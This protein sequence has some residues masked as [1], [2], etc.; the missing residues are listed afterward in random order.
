MFLDFIRTAI[1]GTILGIFTLIPQ[2]NISIG[3]VGQPKTFLPSQAQTDTERVVSELLFRKLFKYQDGKLVNDLVESWKASEDYSTY[4][5]KLKKGNRWHDGIEVSSN[6]IIYTLTNREGIK[7]QIEIEK[8]S[9]LEVKISLTTPNAILP[10]LLTF[11]L[12]PA[13]VPNQNPLRPVGSTSYRLARI[14]MERN[15][16]QGVVLQSFQPDKLYNKLTFNF[17]KNEN[18][19][20]TAYKLGEI[21]TFLSSSTFDW[22]GVEKQPITYLGRYFALIFNTEGE[23]LSP[24]ENRQILAKALN[25]DDLLNKNYYVNSLKAQGSISHSQYTKAEAITDTYD[26]NAALTTNQKAAL[27]E[28]KVLLPNNKDGAQI[29]SFLRDSWEKKLGLKLNFN[30]LDLDDLINTAKNGEF[31]VL[32]IGEEV[33]PDPDRYIFW[34]STQKNTYNLGQ[35]EDLRADKAL[36]EGRKAFDFETRLGHYN[37]F[38]DVIVTKVPAVFLY[39]PGTYLY[40]SNKKPIPIPSVIYSPS[41]IL[42][43]L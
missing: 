22:Q 40:T 8:I 36:E 21:T 5:I 16:V 38:Q 20:S 42:K 18:E 1:I 13:H 28:I 9:P 31:D 23:K 41:D 15:N 37:I 26:T 29:E 25:V 39:H 2:S 27:G 10:N 24:V 33:G 6:D 17:Y 14:D 30:F 12:E 43:N 35:F 11:G 3:L 32:F 4:N 34:H 7:D 19:L